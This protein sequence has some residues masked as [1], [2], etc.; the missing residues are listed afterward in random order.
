MNG[1]WP[2]PP[3]APAAAGD[4]AGF[5]PLLTPSFITLPVPG[6]AAVRAGLEAGRTPGHLRRLS[7]VSPTPRSADPCDSQAYPSTE[8]GNLDMGSPAPMG[9]A[10]RLRLPAAALFVRSPVS[11]GRFC[12]L[13]APSPR[14]FPRQTKSC[15]A[16]RS[17]S[18]SAPSPPN[19]KAALGGRGT[20]S[21]A[22][23]EQAGSCLAPPSH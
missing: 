23:A 16:N 15:F 20:G 12:L 22:E 13:P 21:S 8:S 17:V 7:R 1:V 11:G 9:A 18:P 5:A 14:P 2:P 19:L 10:P 4:T 6:N 3:G